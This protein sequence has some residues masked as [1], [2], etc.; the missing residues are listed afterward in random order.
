MVL[1]ALHCGAESGD[2][3]YLTELL[4]NTS[5]N[6]NKENKNTKRTALHMAASGGHLDIVKLLHQHK[7]ELN[8]LDVNGESAIHYC[9]RS[10]NNVESAKQ[11]IE[12]LV[13]H[14]VSM[15][16]QNKNGETALHIASRYGC[17]ELVRCLCLCGADLDLQDDVNIIINGLFDFVFLF[18]LFDNKRN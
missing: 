18:G 14:G 2:L 6:V 4:E 3:E 15:N 9:V 13:K 1:T 7:I 16:V 8:A 17:A 12:Y 10:S 5:L 11:I